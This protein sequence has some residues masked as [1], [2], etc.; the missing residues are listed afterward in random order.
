MG[1]EKTKFDN[2]KAEAWLYTEQSRNKPV[3]NQ[4]YDI[5]GRFIIQ[6]FET[7]NGAVEA[8]YVFT[9][10][11]LETGGRTLPGKVYIFGLLSD[12]RADKSLEMEW[13]TTAKK[14][15]A[16]PR[17]KQGYYNYYYAIAPTASPG[18]LD[19]IS[20]EGTYNQTENK[21]DILVYF[22]PIGSRYDQLIGYGNWSYY[23]KN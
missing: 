18:T 3:Y 13:D 2:S 7:Q 16:R 15:T 10:F 19:N 1:V 6:N 4:Q 9:N 21:Y 23:G 22:R 20:L 8:D 17:L 11:S 12:W 14:Y 5:N